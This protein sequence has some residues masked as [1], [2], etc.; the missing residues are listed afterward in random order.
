[1]PRFDSQIVQLVIAAIVALALLMQ[2]IVLLAIFFALRKA[3]MKIREDFED[4]RAT[5]VPFVTDAR[6]FFVKVAP[7]VEETTADVAAIAHSWRVQSAEIQF[8]ATEIVERARRQA[9]R[10]DTMT[11]G[12]LDAAERAGAFVSD[13]VAKPMRQL[14]GILASVKAV[15]E[16][17]RTPEPAP[18]P[19]TNHAPSRDPEMFV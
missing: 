8:A 10:L 1:M 7:R 6:E 19:K 11:T 4:I 9:G 3:A 15:V 13:A 2:A 18:R 12:I 5:V 14:S 17:L 16:T